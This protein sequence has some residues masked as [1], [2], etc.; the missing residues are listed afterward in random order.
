MIFS[1]HEMGVYDVPSSLDLIYKVTGRND[2]IVIGQS[3][4]TNIQLVYSSELPDHARKRVKFMIYL[5]PTIF[6]RS[7]RTPLA[8]LTNFWPV[9]QVC[10]SFT[11]K[12]NKLLKKEIYVT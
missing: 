8:K 11:T 2:I 12:T 10:S 5:A 3:M 6:L 7:M 4:G 9:I 1:Y